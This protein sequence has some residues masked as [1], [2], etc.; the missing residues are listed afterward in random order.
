MTM[1]SYSK[2]RILR[3]PEVQRYTGLSKSGL[4]LAIQ[5]GNF[6]RQINIGKRAVGWL[7]SDIDAWVQERI[8]RRVQA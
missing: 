3:R 4:Y 1:E 8:A 7:E 6:P 2:T 5:Q